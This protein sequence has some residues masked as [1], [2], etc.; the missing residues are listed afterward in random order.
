MLWSSLEVQ[1][2]TASGLG[3]SCGASSGH[4]AWALCEK[5][6]RAEGEPSGAGES[7]PAH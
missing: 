7:G 2:P 5:G 3:E 4:D 1:G 6:L